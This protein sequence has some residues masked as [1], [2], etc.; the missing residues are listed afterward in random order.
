MIWR[1][2]WLKYIQSLK[3]KANSS[4]KG[5][6]PSS[7]RA[8][9]EKLLQARMS[10]PP[11]DWAEANMGELRA[12]LRAEATAGKWTPSLNFPL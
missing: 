3:F 12:F 7:W 6:R 11:K 9:N 4:T 2:L 1:A 8:W 10:G 5:P